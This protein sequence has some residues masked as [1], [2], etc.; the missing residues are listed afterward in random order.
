MITSDISMMVILVGQNLTRWPL[1][2]SSVLIKDVFRSH[3][4]MIDQRGLAQSSIQW[5]DIVALNYHIL[6]ATQPCISSA[7]NYTVDRTINTYPYTVNNFMPRR[8]ITAWL[9]WRENFLVWC[10]HFSIEVKKRYRSWI[11]CEWTRSARDKIG[12]LWGH[13]IL[14]YHW[15]TKSKWA[16]SKTFLTCTTCT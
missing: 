3:N 1:C 4:N 6:H 14:L 11:G 13:L 2:P 10:N 15:G 5:Y 8:Q 12:L 7:E 9:L 16:E